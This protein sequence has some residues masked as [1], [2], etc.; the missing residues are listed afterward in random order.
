LS[1]L[2]RLCDDTHFVEMVIQ[3]GTF[4]WLD[5][6]YLFIEFS[7]PRRTTSWILRITSS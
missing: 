6:F 5:N 1:L 2:G 4:A 7:R 3:V